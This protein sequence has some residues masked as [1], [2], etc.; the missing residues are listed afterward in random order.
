LLGVAD[1]FTPTSFQDATDISGGLTAFNYGSRTLIESVSISFMQGQ[2][3][4]GGDLSV[5]GDGEAMVNG[6]LTNIA[7]QA[8]K[9]AGAVSYQIHN[10]DTGEVL[11]AGIGEPHR[12]DVELT[13]QT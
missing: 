7:F 4:S 3:G 13:I 10:A 6:L 2:L 8:D 5:T 12:A 9:S 11:A 1:S